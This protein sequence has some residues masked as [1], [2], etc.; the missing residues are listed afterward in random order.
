M[1]L[2]KR[3]RKENKEV[4]IYLNNRPLLQV[5]GMKCLGI[6]FDHKLT[7]KEHI[8]YMAEKCTKLMFSLSKSAKLNWRLQHAAIKSI[9]TGKIVPLLLYG[10]PI[11]YKAVEIASNKL[12]LIRVQRII[13]IKIANAYRT[14]SNEALYALTG[15]TPITIKIQ[16]A[17]QYYSIIRGPGKRIQM[18]KQEWEHNTGNTLPK[19]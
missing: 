11:W 7:F 14:V 13:N 1:L 12:K 10:A 18:S 16:E 3:K 4:K 6:I 2:T 8:N 19:Q 17:Y 15:L 9:Y 5:K